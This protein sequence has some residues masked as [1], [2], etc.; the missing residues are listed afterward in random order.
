MT[1][2]TSVTPNLLVRDVASST[3]FYRDV[4]GFTMSETVPDKEPF[5]FVWLEARRRVGV[6]QRHQGRRGRYP[7]AAKL[8]PAAPP[9]CF[10]LSPASTGYHAAWRRRPR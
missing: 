10:S 7:E 8:P 3:A 6:P 1:R 9:R 5:V 4:L 2:F